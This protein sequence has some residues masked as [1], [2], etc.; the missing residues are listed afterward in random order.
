MD[1]IISAAL[2]HFTM[3]FISFR[4]CLISK[5]PI[6]WLERLRYIRPNLS[7]PLH[8]FTVR[9]ADRSGSWFPKTHDRR[10]V[11]REFHL[12]ELC[13]ASA[14]SAAE[15]NIPLV[16]RPRFEDVLQ[17]RVLVAGFARVSHR[18]NIGVHTYWGSHSLCLDIMLCHHI[19]F[20]HLFL[21]GRKV[22]RNTF[23]HP[24]IC[25]CADCTCG[26]FANRNEIRGRTHEY[27]MPLAIVFLKWYI[28]TQVINDKIRAAAVGIKHI[29]LKITSR[30]WILGYININNK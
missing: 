15:G 24:L 11:A 16:S 7:A 25:G 23:C 6:S 10:A 5:C 18:R 12:E 4:Q 20:R 22:V 21:Y 14:P 9:D 26:S 17:R 27:A 8:L 30:R 19:T 29:A 28:A 2:H 3:A 13:V 1:I